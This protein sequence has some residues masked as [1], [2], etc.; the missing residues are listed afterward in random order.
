MLFSVG[1]KIDITDTTEAITGLR[2]NVKKNIANDLSEFVKVKVLNWGEHLEEWSNDYD[3]IIGADIIYIEETFQQLLETI[4]HL[5]S[6]EA[7]IYLASKIRYDRDTNFLSLL[8]KHFTV[9]EIYY[10][11]RRNIH[12]YQANKICQTA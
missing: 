7:D 5:S 8:Q 11:K 12:I 2:E 3:V 9:K 10:D 6:C 1:G 4:N